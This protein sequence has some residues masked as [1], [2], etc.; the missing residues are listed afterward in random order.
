MNNRIEWLD[1]AKGLG[2]FCIVIG[3][4]IVPQWLSD[5]VF[6]F[7]VPLFFIVSGYFYRQRSLAETIEKGWK[8]LL[9]PM[10]ITIL[11]AQAGMFFLYV[12]HGFWSGPTVGEWLYGVA[13]MSGFG[14]TRGMWFLMSLFW[15]KLWM[16]LMGKLQL[17]SGGQFYA[18]MFL[19]SAGY[20]ISKYCAAPCFFDRGMAVPLFLC[21]GR[22]LKQESVIEREHKRWALCL[23][24]LL[25]SIAW[26]FPVDISGFILPYGVGSVMTT[27]AISIAMLVVLKKA[28][29][30]SSVPSKLLLYAGQNSLIILCVH[31]LIHTWH[32]EGHV[33]N[34]LPQIGYVYRGWCWGAFA[35]FE[36]GFLVVAVYFLQKI[37]VVHRIFHGK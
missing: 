33:W 5:W 31:S 27:V 29:E 17:P 34:A 20:M 35:F 37:P 1:I 25:V 23:A 2:I 18:S 30:L 6:S 12:R 16:N 28:S 19:F 15:G 9:R 4:N 3:H 32:I 22:W 7:H 21:I 24:L 14:Y 10:L 36:C 13:T 8:Q 11:V 26:M